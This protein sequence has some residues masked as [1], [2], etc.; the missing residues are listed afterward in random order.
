MGRDVTAFAPFAD[1]SADGDVDVV[2]PNRAMPHMDLASGRGAQLDV[3][4]RHY[5]G[6]A[7]CPDSNRLCHVVSL[8]WNFGQRGLGYSFGWRSRTGLT[9]SS[10]DAMCRMVDSASQLPTI[11]TLIGIPSLPVPNLIEMPGSPV[12][13]S[14]TVAP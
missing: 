9:L 5:I 8:V 7:N 1:L 3:L 12:T 13:L 11:W 10:S 4:P 6:P 2:N 14:G